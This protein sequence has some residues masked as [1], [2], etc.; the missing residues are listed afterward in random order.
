MGTDTLFTLFV[1]G[2]LLAFVLQC[3]IFSVCIYSFLWNIAFN[4]WLTY[5]FQIG[6]IFTPFPQISQFQ[7]YYWYSTL[8]YPTY[9]ITPP[10]WLVIFKCQKCHIQELRRFNSAKFFSFVHPFSDPPTEFVFCFAHSFKIALLPE[11]QQ[12]IFRSL[13]C[14]LHC[15]HSK[16]QK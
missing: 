8:T 6:T 4:S 15:T 7:Y 11:K 13:F 14:T 3:F 9:E 16:F 12:A 1:N 2:I 5:S 10:L